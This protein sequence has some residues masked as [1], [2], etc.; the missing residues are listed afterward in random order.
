MNIVVASLLLYGVVAVLARIAW[1]RHDGS[2]HSA[3]QHAGFQARLV[4]PRLVFAVLG[5]GFIAALV[6]PELVAS[7]IGDDTGVVGLLIASA[8]GA[9][10]PGGPMLAFAVGSA[11]L[12]VGAGTPQIIA[13]VTAW[14]L[15]NV[16]RTTIWELPIVGRR[17][18]LQRLAV[19]LPA[20]L[21]LGL[22]TGELVALLTPAG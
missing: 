19:A 16:N 2:F 15:Y 4:A 11:A 8:L 22:A 7:I 5:A 20:P 12:D 14:G 17:A 6:P 18:T 10:T 9:A 3:L 1:R 13:Y 21:L